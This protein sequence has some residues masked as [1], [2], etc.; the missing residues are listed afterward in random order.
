MDADTLAQVL[1]RPH[2]GHLQQVLVDVFV[3][4]LVVRNDN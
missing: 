4:A 1:E 3:T 2:Y